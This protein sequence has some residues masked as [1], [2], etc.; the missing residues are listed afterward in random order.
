[1]TSLQ[2]ERM[3]HNSRQPVITARARENFAE[4]LITLSFRGDNRR[5]RMWTEPPR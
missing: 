1:M 2:G 4:P 5:P 3:R